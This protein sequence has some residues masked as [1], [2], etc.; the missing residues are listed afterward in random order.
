ML[1]LK[2][3][4]FDKTFTPLPDSEGDEYFANGIFEFNITKILEFI[5]KNPEM[6]SPEWVDVA[7]I[8]RCPSRTLKE[9]VIM[10]A[11]LSNPILLAEISPGNFNVIDGNHRLERAYREGIGKIQAFRILAHQHV[12]FLTSKQAYQSYV[13]YWNSKV[14][15][16]D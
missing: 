11:E 7:I 4:K 9:E 6:F 13:E 10:K 5:R 16:C 12:A 3:M 14:E 15:D 1:V 8:R 2:K